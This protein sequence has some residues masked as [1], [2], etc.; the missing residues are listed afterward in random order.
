MQHEHLG[1]IMANLREDC[2]G[3]SFGKFRIVN[4]EQ[5]LHGRARV[6]GC[7]EIERKPYA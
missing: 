5:D 6:L 2:V 3:R 7:C 4:H 1:M